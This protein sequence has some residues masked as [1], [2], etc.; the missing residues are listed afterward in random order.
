MTTIWGPAFD[1][2]IDYRRSTMI[3]A[4]APRRAGRALRSSRTRRAQGRAAAERR[5]RAAAAS[6][7]RAGA[8]LVAGFTAA[9]PR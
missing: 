3:A 2:E 8:P 4:A 9:S 1:A 6:A 5:A 7:P